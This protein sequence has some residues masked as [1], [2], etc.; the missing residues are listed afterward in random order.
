M[1]ENSIDGLIVFM[2]DDI[3][4][5]LLDRDELIRLVYSGILPVTCAPPCLPAL[6][7]LLLVEVYCNELDKTRLCL[8]F[9]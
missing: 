1:D 8:G 9:V 5:P 6:S 3:T 2:D 7:P 4:L